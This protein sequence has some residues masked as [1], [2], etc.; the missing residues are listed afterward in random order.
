MNLP[1]T[2]QGGAG[3]R[4]CIG[5]SPANTSCSPA[6]DNTPSRPGEHSAGSAEIYNTE[7]LVDNRLID[8]GKVVTVTHRPPFTTRKVPG[9]SWY[10]FLVEAAS[11]PGP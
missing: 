7:K 2:G 1:F 10:S 5:C 8:G 3:K 11:T 4:P 6:N 9:V